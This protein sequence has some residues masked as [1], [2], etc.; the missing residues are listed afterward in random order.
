MVFKVHIA[1]WRDDDPGVMQS[2]AMVPQILALEQGEEESMIRKVH[3]SSDSRPRGFAGTL[4]DRGAFLTWK[5]LTATKVRKAPTKKP[6]QDAA[7]A[8]WTHSQWTG[9][10]Q[11]TNGCGIGCS[12]WP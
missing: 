12:L 11:D 10:S 1:I 5:S 9:A 2:A 6:A 7:E 4:A 8:D 3:H